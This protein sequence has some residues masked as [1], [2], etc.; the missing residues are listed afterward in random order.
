[1]T[2]TGKIARLPHEIREQLNR[3]L[4]DGKP[5]RK[6]VDWLNDLPAVREVMFRDF[7]GRAIN[8]QNLSEWKRGGFRDWQRRQEGLQCARC[9]AGPTDDPAHPAGGQGG[10]LAGVLAAKLV[11]DTIKL[12]EE[13]TDSRERWRY[14][15]RALRQLARSP[16]K[17]GSRRRKPTPIQANPG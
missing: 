16:I 12:L 1:M 13:T 6:L 9:L 7:E 14:L 8:E 5:G 3:R 15:C 17:S 11:V 4:L 2:R 10:R